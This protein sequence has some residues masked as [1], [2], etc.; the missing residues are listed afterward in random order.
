MSTDMDNADRTLLHIPGKAAVPTPLLASPRHTLTLF[1]IVIG[2][3]VLGAVNGSAGSSAHHAPDPDRM[4]RNDLVMIGVLWWWVIF[5]AKGMRERG[6]SVL[7]FFDLKSLSPARI[8]ADVLWAALAFAAIYACDSAVHFLLRGHAA[9]PD[10]PLL[11]ATPQGVAGVAVWLCL[12]ISAGVCEEIVFRGY[13]Q[14]QLVALSGRVALAVLAQGILF[15]IGHAYEG[16]A[17]VLGIVVHGV[18]LGCLA[19][20]RGNIRASVIEHAGWD[21]VAGFGLLGANW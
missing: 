13:L 15:G 1:V 3:T 14:R 10:N 16:L 6:Q 4:L 18:L 21:I 11:S 12:S 20:W 17:S 2:L 7:Q 8:G 19:Q 9:Q 5:I